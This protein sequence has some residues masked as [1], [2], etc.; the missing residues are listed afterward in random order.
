MNKCGILL[1]FNK[2][3]VHFSCLSC[4]LIGVGKSKLPRFTQKTIRCRS[5]RAWKVPFFLFHS[6]LVIRNM[7]EALENLW[8]ETRSSW[9]IHL[10]HVDSCWFNLIYILVVD[11]V[12]LDWCSWFMMMYTRD[13]RAGW[14]LGYVSVIFG[15]GF[16]R[17]LLR[18]MKQT[19]STRKQGFKCIKHAVYFPIVWGATPLNAL[20]LLSSSISLTPPNRIY[21]SSSLN[22]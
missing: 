11:L 16:L 7:S 13:K 4:R 19:C 2:N 15:R 3:H 21:C 12:D 17:P 22:V 14:L 18:I 10:I 6:W 20:I 8:V 5:F 1:L 9:S